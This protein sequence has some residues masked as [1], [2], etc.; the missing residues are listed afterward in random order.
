MEYDKEG[1]V[2]NTREK[3]LGMMNEDDEQKIVV[4]H[5]TI[6]QSISVLLLRLVLIEIFAAVVVILFY[7]LLITTDIRQGITDTISFFGISLFIL[8]VIGKI[9]LVIFVIVHWLNEYYE[10]T[11]KEIIYRTG[12]IFKKEERHSL[13]HLAKIQIDQSVL[14]RIFNYGTL[15]LYNWVLEKNVMI[16]LIHNPKK[17]HRILESIL[18]RADREK[19]ML[20]EH[21]LEPEEID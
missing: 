8:L 19:Q 10:I 15:K 13:S 18:P 3:L 5:V 11:P 2:M 7:L 9:S 21:I 12:F 16:Y 20:R 1:G 4:T 14:G 6:R 17:Y